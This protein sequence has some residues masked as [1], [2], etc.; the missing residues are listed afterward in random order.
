MLSLDSFAILILELVNILSVNIIE[1]GVGLMAL[2]VYPIIQ[3][4]VRSL[5]G[6]PSE[7]VMEFVEQREE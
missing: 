5:N 6:N 1:G 4:I 2:M 7:S 3:L